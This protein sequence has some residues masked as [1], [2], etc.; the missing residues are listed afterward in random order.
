MM[1]QSPF[2]AK[3]TGSRPACSQQGCWREQLQ[4][5]REIFALFEALGSYLV[6]QVARVYE[7]G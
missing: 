1:N 4:A 7:W 3:T 6:P 5:G 2:Q